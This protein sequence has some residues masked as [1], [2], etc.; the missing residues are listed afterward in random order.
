MDIGKGI[1]TFGMWMAVGVV[2]YK[3]PESA[4]ILGFFAAF[5]TAVTWR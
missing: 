2:G 4:I 1:G 3:D 5:A